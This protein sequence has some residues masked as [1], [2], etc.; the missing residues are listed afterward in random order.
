MRCFIR[1]KGHTRCC[2]VY[3]SKRRRV[4]EIEMKVAVGGVAIGVDVFHLIVQHD[5]DTAVAMYL[6]ILLDQMYGTLGHNYL[7]AILENPEPLSRHRRRFKVQNP[8]P[9]ETAI[10]Y[11]AK[12]GGTCANASEY[13]FWNGFH[14]SELANQILANDLLSSGISLRKTQFFLSFRSWVREDGLGGSECHLLCQ[15]VGEE[16]TRFVLRVDNKRDPSAQK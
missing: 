2:A 7:V 3:D 12:L 16:H 15:V 10:L 11:N 5:M 13:V 14:P 4:A 8:S 9:S 1:W 6:V